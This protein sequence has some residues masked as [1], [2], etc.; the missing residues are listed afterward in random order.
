MPGHG[1]AMMQTN[2]WVD[3]IY[4]LIIILASGIIYTK[5][6]EIY[7]LTGHKGIK[8]FRN[9][10]LFFAISYLA[11]FFLLSPRIW[12]TVE[13]ANLIFPTIL[14]I[15]VYASTAAVLYLLYSAMWKKTH[16]GFFA[17]SWLLHVIA[18]VVAILTILFSVPLL[19][20]IL[21]A[22]I[23]I[24][25]AIM[26]YLNHRKAKTKKG[27]S[28]VYYIYILL[29]VFWILNTFATALPPFF[30]QIKLFVYAISI[31]LFI[32]ILTRVVKRLSVKSNDKKKG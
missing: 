21:Q 2:L 31:I 17:K 22:I 11:H 25:A 3:A 10:F 26:S 18:L 30:L 12:R 7:A 29:F 24:Y 13:F 15:T 6:R 20:V 32:I 9:V 28:K 14:F 19:F 1:F 27:F 5:T 16:K 4:T 8:Y 23:F